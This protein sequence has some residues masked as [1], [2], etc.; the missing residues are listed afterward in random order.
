LLSFDDSGKQP[1]ERLLYLASSQRAN[2]HNSAKAVRR[3]HEDLLA[4]VSYREPMRS[5]APDQELAFAKGGFQATY[6]L[7][8]IASKLRRLIWI[9]S[10]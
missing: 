2:A 8:G 9:S 4:N 10:C 5:S 7:I 3:R 1:F 6:M